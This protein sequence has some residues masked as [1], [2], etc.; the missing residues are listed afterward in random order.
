MRLIFARESRCRVMRRSGFLLALISLVASGEALAQQTIINVPS[1]DLTPRGRHF[2]LHES[3]ILPRQAGR[4]FG[5]TNFY[6]YGLTPR[7]ELAATVYGIDNGGSREV[8]LGLG[9]KS[10]FEIPEEYAP[11]LGAKLTFGHMTPFS[12]RPS[13]QAVGFFTYGHLS[14]DVPRTDLRL[15][16]GVAG[17][18]RNLLGEDAASVIAGAE[19]PITD[20]L[21]FTGEWFS[22]NHN[23]SALI[24]GL[25]YHRGDWIAVAGYKLSNDFDPDKAGVVLEVGRFFGGKKKGSGDEDGAYEEKHFGDRRPRRGAIRS[26]LAGLVPG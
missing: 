3:A 7:T 23:F 4:V 18:S 2:F 17:G 11:D 9:F 22:G 19:Y 26:A 8:T 24:P 10:V 6:T 25:T 13:K 15:L 14:F 21:A 5:T 20:H 12:L 16:A 1:D